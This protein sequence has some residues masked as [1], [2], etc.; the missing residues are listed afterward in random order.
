MLQ[1]S[2]Q[3]LHEFVGG[4]PILNKIGL[5]VR[6]RNGEVK[7]RMILDTKQSGLKHCAAKHE[8]VLLPRL[9]DTI[10]QALNL[11]STCQQGEELDFFVLDYSDAFWQI[12]LHPEERRF[13][14]AKVQIGGKVQY[15]VF[16]RAVQGSR[17]APL[18]WA[19]TAALVMR[20]TQ[21]AI[22]K[23]NARLH[24]FVDDPIASIRGCA[25]DRRITVAMMVTIWE[26]L[27]FK[28]AYRKGPLGKSVDWIGGHLEIKTDGI[29]ASAKET[30][31][32]DISDAVH[33]FSQSNILSKKDVR[34]FVGRA[35]HAAGLLVT[36]RPFLQSIWASL[37]SDGCE[38]HNSIWRKQIQHS[39][40]WLSAFLKAE[41]PGMLRRFTQ[42]EYLQK[43]PAIEIGTDA[44]P[45]G[46]GGWLAAEGHIVKYFACPVSTDDLQ[47]FGIEKDSCSGQQLLEALAILIALRL[48]LTKT[49]KRVRVS[50]RGDNVG[51][52]SL[53]M[54]MRPSS[55]SLAIIARE[56]ALLTV[57]DA[58][59]PR[60]T[61]TPGVAHV[62]A[63]ML[64]RVHDPRK[65]NAADVFSH[66]ALSHAEETICTPRTR[67]WYAARGD[68]SPQSKR[69]K[70]G[71]AP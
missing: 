13:F 34:S 1:Q 6:E 3:E 49:D 2:R 31:V 32:Q 5:I 17:S 11:Q 33:K 60:V 37:A 9:L 64:S 70:R 45:Y 67:D 50:V 71:E 20:L 24:C 65:K 4:A 29:D 10:V 40:S 68:A 8:R 56:I 43:G 14:C 44:S 47:I 28:L 27:G 36:L 25:R 15:V 61:H 48:W 41:V 57:K 16:L 66:P 30:I 52:L 69:A 63:D 59:P 58:F 54:K 21:S 39:L 38:V 51:A 46:M 12:P 55:A 22:G 35:N 26:A 18:N 19:R 42:D 7:K 62:V 53:V 23:E